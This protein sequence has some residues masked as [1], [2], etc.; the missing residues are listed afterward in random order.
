MA[1]E[2]RKMKD[3]VKA[4]GSKRAMDMK[5]KTGVGMFNAK[6]TMSNLT[7]SST[8]KQMSNMMTRD[9]S[10]KKDKRKKISNRSK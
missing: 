2:I 3:Q 10:K 9:A 6:S 8:K 1:Y 4:A 7:S 5:K